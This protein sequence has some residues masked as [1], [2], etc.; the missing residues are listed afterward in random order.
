MTVEEAKI[1]VQEGH[2]ELAS[3]LPKITASLDFIENGKG[4]K[5]VITSLAK[6]RES[7]AGQAGTTIEP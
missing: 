4:R 5:A 2:F 3:M 7:I 6:A 1:F